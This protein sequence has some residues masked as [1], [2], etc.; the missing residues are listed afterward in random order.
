MSAR[1]RA[2]RRAGIKPRGE[3]TKQQLTSEGETVALGVTVAATVWLGDTVAATDWLGDTVAATD[4]LGDTVAAT[5]WL[6][7]AER[8]IDG[9][10]LLLDETDGDNVALRL[11]VGLTLVVAATLPVTE[12]DGETVG[13]CSEKQ[14]VGDRKKP[15]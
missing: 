4:W 2:A 6:G 12:D 7:V 3:T 1:G 14:D 5:D 10:P 11:G 8:E 15:V 13:S 9:L